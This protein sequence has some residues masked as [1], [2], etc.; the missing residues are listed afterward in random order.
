MNSALKKLITFKLHKNI[1]KNIRE[2]DELILQQRA[3]SWNM[4]LI[5]G[6]AIF[7]WNCVISQQ[8]FRCIMR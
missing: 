3:P 8:S 1:E 7:H 4:A 5:T 6:H 2:M